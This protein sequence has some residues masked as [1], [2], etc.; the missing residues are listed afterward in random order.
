M[1][2]VQ[3]REKAEL[4]EQERKRAVQQKA[5][6]AARIVSQTGRVLGELEGEAKSKEVALSERKE[7]LAALSARMDVVEDAATRHT[8][9]Q[10]IEDLQ[11]TMEELSEEVK[12]YQAKM[13]ELQTRIDDAAASVD[14][15]DLDEARVRLE[16]RSDARATDFEELLQVE[17][18]VYDFGDMQ[19]L[20]SPGPDLDIEALLRGEEPQVL[21]EVGPDEDVEGEK[22]KGS[23]R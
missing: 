13:K 11:E 19:D 6:E 23:A 1:C 20:I 21:G 5:E 8:L 3:V 7:R 18:D 10:D 2:G 17:D 22:G 16:R 12:D 4:Q 15:D 14:A 9:Q